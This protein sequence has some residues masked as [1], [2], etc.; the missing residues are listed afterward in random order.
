LVRKRRPRKP[1]IPIESKLEQEVGAI[2]RKLGY[3]HTKQFPIYSTRKKLRGVFDFFLETHRLA[4]EVNG[5][6]WHSDP[7]KYPD[8]PKYK[9]QKRNMRAWNK[10]M[11]QAHRQFIGVLV[12]WEIDL[13][14]AD[15][16]YTYVRDTIKAYL[17]LQR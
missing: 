13:K 16:M 3:K 2:I 8:G 6:Y 11:Y 12:L 7:R 15:D 10:K 9:V 5:T 1:F 14:E 4:I 17:K